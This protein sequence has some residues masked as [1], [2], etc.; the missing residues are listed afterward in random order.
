MQGN[1]S[2]SRAEV[3]HREA[4]IAH[5]STAIGGNPHKPLAVGEEMIHEVVRQ[6]LRHVQVHGVETFHELSL[7]N[8]IPQAQQ[9][10]NY[11]PPFLHNG[12][13]PV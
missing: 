8:S 5:E 7:G 1:A 2:V 9:Q 3:H 13:S 12:P 11:R 6:S 10:K 4:V